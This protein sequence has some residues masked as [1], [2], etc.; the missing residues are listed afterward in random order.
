MTLDAS[1]F[2][3]PNE[4]HSDGP[5]PEIGTLTGFVNVL[6]L[7][8]SLRLAELGIDMPL[9]DTQKTVFRWLQKTYIGRNGS[10]EALFPVPLSIVR[11]LSEEISLAVAGEIAEERP[12]TDPWE[13]TP[14]IPVPLMLLTI[15][16]HILTI[17]ARTA[18]HNGNLP[19]ME[20]GMRNVTSL[21]AHLAEQVGNDLGTEQ[22]V[23]FPNDAEGNRR[24]Y[25]GLAYKLP[26]SAVAHVARYLETSA[27]RLGSGEWKMDSEEASLADKQL[28]QQ[29]IENILDMSEILRNLNKVYGRP[30]GPGSNS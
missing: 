13:H 9:D 21:W 17:T 18:Y 22:R 29:F 11:A 24:V 12:G 8:V 28:D 19:W 26:Q 30:V 10:L 16:G 23:E 27:E 2:N 1:L 4:Y 25:P 3:D 5:E 14:E 7:N 15:I 6:S 20:Q